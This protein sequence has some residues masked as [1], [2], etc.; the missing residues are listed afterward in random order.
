MAAQASEA[1]PTMWVHD[2][3][4]A[5]TVI[6]ATSYLV[7]LIGALLHNAAMVLG[8]SAAV[9]LSAATMVILIIYDIISETFS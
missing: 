3:I 2:T 5:F 6:M 8:G 9:G 7:L 4:V 1:R